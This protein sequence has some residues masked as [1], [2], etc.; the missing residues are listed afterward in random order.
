MCFLSGNLDGTFG[1]WASDIPATTDDASGHPD[2]NDTIAPGYGGLNSIGQVCPSFSKVTPP[3][4]K[5][6][7]PSI[8]E[9]YK[10]PQNCF[11]KSGEPPV[12]SH[13][14]FPESG[15]PPVNSHGTFHDSGE[16]SVNS[17][18]TFPESGEPSVST[19]TTFPKDGEP[20]VS[21]PAT[22]HQLVEP[23]RSL[24]LPSNKQNKL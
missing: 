19:H 13:T 16:P 10:N 8:G 7:H 9:L 22:I 14:T 24:R 15:E 4:V 3:V 18:T 2:G 21:I 12:S 11:P 17:H 1:H 6:D 20:P 23:R 5:N